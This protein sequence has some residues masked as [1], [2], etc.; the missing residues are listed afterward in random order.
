MPFIFKRA[1]DTLTSGSTSA[2]VGWMLLYGMSRGVYTL[3]QEP[4]ISLYLTISHYIS[5]YLTIS[6]YISLYLTI[7]PRIYT[8][9]PEPHAL[10]TP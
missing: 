1:I 8:L 7:S 9:L 5:L 4:H 6:H 3:L 2:A 10:S